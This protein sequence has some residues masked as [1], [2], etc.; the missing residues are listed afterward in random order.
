MVAVVAPDGAFRIGST[1]ICTCVDSAGTGI[2]FDS[3][4]VTVTGNKVLTFSSFEVVIAT[5]S[6]APVVL[7]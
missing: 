3:E 5:S 2:R 1:V 4:L 7:A 6:P